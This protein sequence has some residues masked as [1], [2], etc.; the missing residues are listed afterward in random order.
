MTG[1]P[2]PDDPFSEYETARALGRAT[3]DMAVDAIFKEGMDDVHMVIDATR[4]LAA[5]LRAANLSEPTIA[6]SLTG[7]VL[8]A[9]MTRHTDGQ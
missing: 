8:V 5:Q 3:G 7:L 4:R 1:S 2:D 6:T 9:V